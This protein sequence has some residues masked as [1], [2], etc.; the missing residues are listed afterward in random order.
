MFAHAMEL[1]MAK[2]WKLMSLQLVLFAIL[3]A[4]LQYRSMSPRLYG[5]LETT[6][7]LIGTTTMFEGM[8]ANAFDW[9]Y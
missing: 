8:P 1:S 5:V 2:T 7:I 3:F 6:A 9:A 4:G